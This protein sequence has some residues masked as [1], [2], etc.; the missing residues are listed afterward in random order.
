MKVNVVAN[1]H[2]YNLFMPLILKGQAK[3]VIAISSGFADLDI[4][5]KYDLTT[6]TL[7]STSK[8]AM[9]MVTA[10]FGAQYKADG[11]LF[12]SL[13]PGLV[14]VGHFANGKIPY[15][16]LYSCTSNHVYLNSLSLV[17]ATPEQL[18]G[19]GDLMAKFTEYAPDFKGPSTPEEATLAVNSVWEKASIE[20][21]DNGAFLSHLGNKQWL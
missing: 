18:Q 19:I 15:V 12:L 14:E 11:V 21:G 8:A 2:L 1:I 4:T 5:N 16:I 20:K 9:N 13:C 6:A 10:K 17:T 3:K 7:Y